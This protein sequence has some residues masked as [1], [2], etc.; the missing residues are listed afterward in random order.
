[1]NPSLTQEKHDN[2]NLPTRPLITKEQGITLAQTLFSLQ[3]SPLGLSVVQELDSYIDKNFLVKGRILESTIQDDTNDKEE[4]R[5][6]LKVLNSLASQY[7]DLL[8]IISDLLTFLNSKGVE[9]P[10]PQTSTFGTRNVPC[11]ILGPRQDEKDAHG[12]CT[13]PTECKCLMRGKEVA[14]GI[15]LASDIDGERMVDVCMVGMFS[16][17]PGDI[18]C[19]VKWTKE[20]LIDLGAKI[21][22][23]HRIL[24]EYSETNSWIGGVQLQDPKFQWDLRNVPE[25]MTAHDHAL[26][27]THQKDMIRT[28]S[29]R[30]QEEVLLK[31]ENLD[32]QL[33]HADLNEHNIIA[34][35]KPDG[36]FK[37]QGFID[38]HHLHYSYRVLDVG[39]A[40]GY[41]MMESVRKNFDFIQAS[42]HVLS[43]YQSE[44]PLTSL[45]IDMLLVSAKAR[46]CQSLVFGAYQYKYI[47]PGNKYSLYTSAQGWK[48]LEDLSLVPEHDV[49]KTWKSLK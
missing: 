28:I 43:G 22:H 24:K 4:K 5:Y 37:I 41:V 48:V 20:L 49:M 14:Q 40:L 46:I 21:A 29:Q 36:G 31:L 19:D 2:D 23:L 45:E 34:G 1:T 9:C 17:V 30:F 42:G 12:N 25:V 26:E 15:H 39:V 11:R 10:V 44:F 16:F 38:F 27:T 8:S 33:I 7:R 35:P 3:I 13:S 18:L 47:T 6:V 32:L